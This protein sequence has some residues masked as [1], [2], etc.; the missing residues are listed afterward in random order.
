MRGWYPAHE[1]GHILHRDHI[2]GLGRQ[3]LF[4][5]SSSL[6]GFDGL[7]SLSLLNKTLSRVYDRSQEV[8][9]DS[10]GLSIN[11][12]IF[13]H[14]WGADELF[15]I[16]E[17]KESLFERSL[18]RIAST[19]PPSADRLKHLNFSLGEKAMELTMPIV[20]LKNWAPQLP[21]GTRGP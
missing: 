9:A 1:L 5:I 2:R 6:F 16:L 19:H 7:T 10:F 3:I 21:C 12:K 14:T 4:S 8:N 11:E 17:K 18:A 15:K 20:P 13:G